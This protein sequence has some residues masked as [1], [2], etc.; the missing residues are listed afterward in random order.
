M[1]NQYLG[2]VTEAEWDACTDACSD[3]CATPAPNPA[4]VVNVNNY[5]L[6]EEEDDNPVIAGLKQ[7][8]EDLE[9][10]CYLLERDNRL[11]Q[12]INEEQ[13]VD[14]NAM[15]DDNSKLRKKLRKSNI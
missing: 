13:E 14:L 3:D 15:K 1:S 6:D 2:H 9:L 10:R 8:I 11:L 12:I 7:R 5:V 4:I